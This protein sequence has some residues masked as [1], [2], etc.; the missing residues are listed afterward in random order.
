MNILIAKHNLTKSSDKR[1]GFREDPEKHSKQ[2]R[3]TAKVSAHSEAS[4][5]LSLG[6]GRLWGHHGQE[7]LMNGK[8]C[9]LGGHPAGVE[10]LKNMVLPG[11]GFIT[12][13][14]DQMITDRDLGNNFFVEPTNL[15][16][17]RAEV[18]L[19]SS[20]NYKHNF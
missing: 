16:S 1:Y 10:T 5:S 14:D 4:S 12:I 15:N 9:L 2:I 13:I 3:Q 6:S 18:R 11:I 19:R 8:I 7:L 17:K 20:I